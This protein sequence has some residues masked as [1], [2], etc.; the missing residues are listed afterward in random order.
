MKKNNSDNANKYLIKKEEFKKEKE[1][2]KKEMINIFFLTL[3]II[4]FGYCYTTKVVSSIENK[5]ILAYYFIC[6]LSAFFM[7]YNTKALGD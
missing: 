6:I 1:K 3:S 4:L 2:R 5:N 7:G